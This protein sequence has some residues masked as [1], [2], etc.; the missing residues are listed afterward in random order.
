MTERVYA[1][2][3]TE[4]AV[5]DIDVHHA[6]LRETFG[7]EE[8]DAWRRE[9][10]DTVA[11]QPCLNAAPSPVKAPHSGAALCA[12]C[13]IRVCEVHQPT[14]FCSPSMMNRTTLPL[15]AYSI[16]AIPPKDH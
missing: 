6:R 4:N 13:S 9:L 10:L 1:V 5:R 16:S 7:Q 12:S 8:A 14:A 15:S 11:W 3:L 2:R